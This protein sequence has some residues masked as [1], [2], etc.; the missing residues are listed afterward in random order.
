MSFYRGVVDSLAIELRASKEFAKLEAGIK[1]L[2][3]IASVSEP[4]S[5]QA[6]SQLLSFL[7]HRYP[8]VH[9]NLFALHPRFCFTLVLVT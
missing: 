7:A 5:K 8:K 3:S 4:I 9:V 1:I 2:G 6:F